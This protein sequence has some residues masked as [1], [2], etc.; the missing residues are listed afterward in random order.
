M[1]WVAD[2]NLADEVAD[3]KLADEVADENL[4]D[5][6]LADEKVEVEIIGSVVG[7]VFVER[8]TAKAE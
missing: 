8:K 4:A 6:N 3:E 2:E 1:S 5:E 7:K